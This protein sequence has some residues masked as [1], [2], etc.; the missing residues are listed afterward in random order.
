MKGMGSGV[1]M[2][3]KSDE[4]E[5]KVCE[6]D[7]KKLQE[8]PGQ[9]KWEGVFVTLKSFGC[10]AFPLSVY[11]EFLVCGISALCQYIISNQYKITFR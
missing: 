8:D 1:T 10:L 3:K 2:L 9:L 11:Y 5:S 4:N 6:K 7:G